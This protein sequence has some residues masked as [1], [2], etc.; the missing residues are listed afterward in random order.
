MRSPPRIAE[1]VVEELEVEELAA[2]D[3]GCVLPGSSPAA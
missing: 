3:K 2:E 1:F